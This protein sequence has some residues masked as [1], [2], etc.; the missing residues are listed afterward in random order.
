MTKIDNLTDFAS[1]VSSLLLPDNTIV[2]LA[3][4]FNAATQRW[5]ASVGYKDFQVNGINLCTHP[6]FMR[7]WRNVVPFGLACMTGDYTDPFNIEDFAS[8]RVSL[9][10][11]DAADVLAVEQ[12]VFGAHA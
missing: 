11:L 6:N 12:Q 2:T 4:K 5:A 3:L 10:L 8:G 7:Q 1:Q 9:Y